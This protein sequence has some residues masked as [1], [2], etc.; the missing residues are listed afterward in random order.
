MAGQ[1][2]EIAKGFK[3][4]VEIS[5]NLILIYI[6]L[7]IVQYFSLLNNHKWMKYLM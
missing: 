3:E 7:I 2:M 1:R 4:S 5:L 6:I